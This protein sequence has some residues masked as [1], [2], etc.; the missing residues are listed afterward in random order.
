MEDLNSLDRIKDQYQIPEVLQSCH[1]AIVNG[2]VIEGHVPI[3]EINRLLNDQPDVIGIAV[4][5]MPIGSPGMEIEGF[6]SES[7]DVVT[8]DDEGQIEIYRSY[9]LE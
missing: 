5:G 9:P 4:A 3:A 1:T 2:Y 7:Y 8:F 6:E